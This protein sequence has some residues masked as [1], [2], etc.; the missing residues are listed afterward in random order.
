M[1]WAMQTTLRPCAE[2]LIAPIPKTARIVATTRTPTWVAWLTLQ[3]K[4]PFNGPWR[5]GSKIPTWLVP[6]PCSSRYIPSFRSQIGILSRWVCSWNVCC[7]T[8]LNGILMRHFANVWLRSWSN[9]TGR[10]I[11]NHS[12]IPCHFLHCGTPILRKYLWRVRLSWP[13]SRKHWRDQSILFPTSRSCN[14]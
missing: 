11:K 1:W 4:Q 10:S 7:T 13:V 6:P 12:D 2:Y 14:C 9:L 3:N 5:S 8:K